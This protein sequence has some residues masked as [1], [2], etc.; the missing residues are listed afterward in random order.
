MIVGIRKDYLLFL[1]EG[2]I[3]ES[4]VICFLLLVDLAV[5]LEDRGGGETFATFWTC[6]RLLFGMTPVKEIILRRECHY[7]ITQFS[8]LLLNNIKVKIRSHYLVP[9]LLWNITLNVLVNDIS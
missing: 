6:I 3:T 7:L 4:A 9:V 8:A 2:H 5:T 1:F